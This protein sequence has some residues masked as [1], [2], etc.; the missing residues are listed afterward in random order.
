MENEN[1]IITHNAGF[2]SCYTLR[3]YDIIFYFN[4]NKKCPKFVDSSCQFI[5]YK[6]K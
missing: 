6:I 3:L 4:K 5:D 1:L 2:F